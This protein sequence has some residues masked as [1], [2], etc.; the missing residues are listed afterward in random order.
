MTQEWWVVVVGV[1]SVV[2]S[3][4]RILARQ[5]C[6]RCRRDDGTVPLW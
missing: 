2:F 1:D 3:P 4:G 5:D 6:S